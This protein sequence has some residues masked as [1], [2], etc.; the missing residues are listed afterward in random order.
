MLQFDEVPDARPA[1]RVALLLVLSASFGCAGLNRG[2]DSWALETK[3]ATAVE[4]VVVAPGEPLP[5]ASAAELESLTRPAALPEVEIAPQVRYRLDD[6]RL[7]QESLSFESAVTLRL[8]GS[9]RAVAHRYRRGALGERPVLLWVPGQAIQASD[10]SSLGE[11][12][13]RALDRGFDVVFFVPP[14]HLERS[15]AGFASGDAFLATG[16]ADHLNVFAQELSDVRRLAP[17]PGGAHPRRLRQLDG[18]RGAVADRDLGSVPRLPG[19]QAAAGGLER[20]D[21]PAG[22]DPGARADP[23][24]GGHRERAGAPTARS[25]PGVRARGS[26]PPA[27][28]C[29]RA[30]TI[31]SPRPRAP[32]RSR[33]SGASGGCGSIGAATA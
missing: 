25:T 18:R 12:F 30:A 4:G 15:P 5:F 7:A 16:F 2:I 17:G 1:A 29:C 28:R 21:G 26:I 19:A 10:F 6:E 13:T 33:G 23:G 31:R 32:C 9:Q 3:A 8:S 20:G 27:S 22:D 14:Y 11:Y 24:S